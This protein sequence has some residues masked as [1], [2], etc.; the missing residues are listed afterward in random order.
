MIAGWP[1]YYGTTNSL[2]TKTIIY[3]YIYKIP[4]PDGYYLASLRL[5]F[6]VELFNYKTMTDMFI[7][8]DNRNNTIL[9]NARSPPLG[10]TNT[11]NDTTI[12]QSKLIC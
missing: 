11:G 10:G 1:E 4:V 8:L 12:K 7:I 6:H 9:P 5:A 3:S 2:C